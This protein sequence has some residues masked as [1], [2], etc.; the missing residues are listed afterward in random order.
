MYGQ[1]SFV[2]CTQMVSLLLVCRHSFFVFFFFF[3]VVVVHCASSKSNVCFVLVGHVQHVLPILRRP[4]SVP[5]SPMMTVS[6]RCTCGFVYV[7][8]V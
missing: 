3:F 8:C 2:A 6:A 7:L 1:V 5:S 4:V